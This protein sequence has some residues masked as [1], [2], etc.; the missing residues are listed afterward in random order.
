M[1]FRTDRVVGHN[2]FLAAK[3]PGLLGQ[4]PSNPRVNP[5]LDLGGEMKNFDGHGFSPHTLPRAAAA[6]RDDAEKNGVS[7]NVDLC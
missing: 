3:P 2:Y 5:L 1:L 7:N 4:M 6:A